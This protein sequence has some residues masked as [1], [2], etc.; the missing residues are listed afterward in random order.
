MLKSQPLL[1]VIITCYNYET[2]IDEC[3][4]SV[5]SQDYDNLE[6]IVVDDGRLTALG[7]RSRNMVTGSPPFEAKQWLA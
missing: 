7:V 2:Y 3:I 5:L 4:Q 6:V 1:S